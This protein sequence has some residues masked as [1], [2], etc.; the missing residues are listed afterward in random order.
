MLQSKASVYCGALLR[1]PPHGAKYFPNSVQRMFNC[2]EGFLPKATGQQM[3]FQAWFGTIVQL[4]QEGRW[5]GQAAET[6]QMEYDK[7]G[8]VSSR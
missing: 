6:G 4:Q 5:R 1:F 8:R 7:S 3:S 2:R